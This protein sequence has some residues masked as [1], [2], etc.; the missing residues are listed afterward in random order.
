MEK[1]R[2]EALVD[3]LRAL[4]AKTVGAGCTEAEAL[5]AASMVER[6][7]AQYEID[8]AELDAADREPDDGVAEGEWRWDERLGDEVGQLAM[9]I[10]KLC[11]ASGMRIK[12]QKRCVFWG[13][14]HR[15]EGAYYLLA[16]CERAIESEWFHYSFLNR[17]S[18]RN[19]RGEFKLGMTA[20]LKERLQDMIEAM[21]PWATGNALVVRQNALADQAMRQWMIA[22]NLEFV[23]GRSGDPASD[24]FMG[25][26]AA[27]DRV[28]LNRGIGHAPTPRGVTRRLAIGSS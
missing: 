6:L 27:A 4:R 1:T 17:V 20:R 25:G 22:N 12:A 3:K 10:A 15:L 16:I 23:R 19:T 7:L 11:G 13:Q 24:S 14:P 2:R 5:A 9:L 28:A 8:E 18:D 21:R 26:R